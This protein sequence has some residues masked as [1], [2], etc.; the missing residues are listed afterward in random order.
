[1]IFS[2]CGAVPPEVP[3]STHKPRLTCPVCF[4]LYR[5]VSGLVSKHGY[6][7]PGRGTGYAPHV[8]G[9]CYASRRFPSLEHSPEGTIWLIGELRAQLRATASHVS[10]LKSGKISQLPVEIADP[11]RR[12]CGKVVMATREDIESRRVVARFAGLLTWD[13]V[14]QSALYSAELHE[15]CTRSALEFAIHMLATHH[16]RI[17]PQEIGAH[18]AA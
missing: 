12:G 17:D 2:I 13:Q 18:E 1:M 8:G 14:V 5:E 6:H 7:A 16:P 3:L 4:G 9:S 10:A 15:R 11:E